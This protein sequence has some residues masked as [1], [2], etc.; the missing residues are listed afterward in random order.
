MRLAT[1]DFAKPTVNGFVIQNVSSGG[2]GFA[3][4]TITDIFVVDPTALSTTVAH[5][6]GHLCWLTHRGS[7]GNLMTPGRGDMDSKLTRWQVSVIRSSK[8]ANY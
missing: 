8:Y 4:G 6:T 3:W 7:S 5:E 2:A 1:V